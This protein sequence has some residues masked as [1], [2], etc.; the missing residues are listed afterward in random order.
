[1]FFHG[2]ISVI[3]I[4]QLSCVGGGQWD[5]KGSGWADEGCCDCCGVQTRGGRR[6]TQ[7]FR[8]ARG[9]GGGESN[10]LL[11]WEILL[12]VQGPWH[13]P[14]LQS[15]HQ[16]SRLEFAIPVWVVFNG[17][18]TIWM[19]CLSCYQH[20]ELR[21]FFWMGSVSTRQLW[22]EHTIWAHLR[23]IAT[24]RTIATAQIVLRSFKLFPGTASPRHRSSLFW[25]CPAKNL[26]A[27]IFSFPHKGGHKFC[28]LGPI[29][30]TGLW[31]KRFW[32]RGPLMHLPSLWPPLLGSK[33]ILKKMPKQA[34]KMQNNCKTH[35]SSKQRP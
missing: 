33:H 3:L 22:H 10:T 15:N 34:G 17:W 7:W 30:K 25:R 19:T 26:L 13:N 28:I 6:E 24:A 5:E 31:N 1:M 32:Q 14:Q 11:V 27:C 8:E 21:D 35:L 18:N 2:R 16:P 12:S 23:K 20:G 9:E 29:S 4:S